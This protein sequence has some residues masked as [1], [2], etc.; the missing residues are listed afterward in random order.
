MC[1][2]II[3]LIVNDNIKFI[4]TLCNFINYYN[5]NK[6]QCFEKS[7]AINEDHKSLTLNLYI[8]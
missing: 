8:F 3:I 6:K 1:E 4:F 7:C 5:Y 2:I